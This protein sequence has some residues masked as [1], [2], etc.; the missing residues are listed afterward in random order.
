MRIIY[1]SIKEEKSRP[2]MPCTSAQEMWTKI[3]TAYSES[4]ADSVPLLWS[5]FYG[6]K[7]LPGQTVLEFMSEVEHIVSLL[8]A[9]DGIV[10]LDDLI[11]AMVIMSL[12]KSLKLIFKPVWESTAV[13][14]K[15]LRNLTKRLIELEKDV[16]QTEVEKTT[17]A[18]LSK[19]TDTA[20]ALIPSGFRDNKEKEVKG[21]RECWECGE[22]SHIRANC[23]DY[24]RKQKRKREEEED[25]RDRQRRKWDRDDD[26]RARC[27]RDNYQGRNG[28]YRDDRDRGGRDQGNDK[29][30][31]GRRD[32][33]ASRKDDDGG[34]RAYSYSAATLDS[35]VNKPTEWFADSG[36]TQHMTGN[37]DLLVNFVPT[38]QSVGWCPELE[39]RNLLLQD[40]EI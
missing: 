22:T 31:S 35:R 3:E 19:K 26:D 28:R 21:A 38:N 25:G 10:I 1:S 13:A 18:L 6:C 34:R 37:R 20:H 29:H 39:N 30:D 27:D 15:T 11:I 7:F 2:L 14:E 12:P 9:I 24:K 33:K 23:R 8:K 4:A 40:M 16:K 36:A 5:R 32:Q 17:E